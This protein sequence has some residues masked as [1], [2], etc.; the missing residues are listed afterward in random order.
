MIQA[1][2]NKIFAKLYCPQKIFGWY[3]YVSP[4][5]QNQICKSDQEGHGQQE[6]GNNRNFYWNKILLVFSWYFLL[7]MIFYVKDIIKK[8]SIKYKKTT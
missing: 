7:R 4:H 8:Y 2:F 1:I 5:G 3:G 6:I